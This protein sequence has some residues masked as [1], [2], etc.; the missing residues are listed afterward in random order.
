MEENATFAP[1]ANIERVFKAIAQLPSLRELSIK[2]GYYCDIDEPVCVDRVGWLVAGAA[3]LDALRIDSVDLHSQENV[4]ALAEILSKCATL[5]R[6][7]MEIVVG[8][9]D[10]TSVAPLME[11]LSGL[12]NLT[13]LRLKI[14][15]Y[16]D[17]VETNR[18]ADEAAPILAACVGAKGVVKKPEECYDVNGG[19]VFTNIQPKNQRSR[20]IK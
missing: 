17:F 18:F 20:N 9:R 15:A 6:L 16:G 3:N 5:K 11:S 4:V 7:H 14:D 10:V 13:E 12:T 2:Y 1:P 8:Y 19:V